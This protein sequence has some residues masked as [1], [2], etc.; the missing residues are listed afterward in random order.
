MPAPP[1][2]RLLPALG[3]LALL[4][5]L[6]LA[7]AAAPAQAR[8][9]D[10]RVEVRVAGHCGRTSTA[11]LRLRAEDGEIRV[12]TEV[13]TPKYGVWRLTVLHERRTVAR[14]RVRATRSGRGF[15]HR[16]VVPDYRGAD[17][18][19]IRAVAPGG[20]TCTATATVPGS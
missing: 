7:L 12:D 17:A 13:R 10:D 16:V 9:D 1:A 8:D 4:V 11:R 15:Q 3:L 20:E 2:R 5:A 19:S 18:V 6:A 14:A